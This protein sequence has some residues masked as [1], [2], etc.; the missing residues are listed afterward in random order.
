M[1]EFIHIAGTNGK[2]STAYYLADIIT[3]FDSCGLF[4]S[5][6]LF[7]P[8]ERFLVNGKQITQQDYDAYMREERTDM[9]EHLF[10]VW[11]RI[12]LRWFSDMH[13]DYAVIEAG[14]GGKNDCTNEID[15][16]IQILTPINY[17]HTEL[18]GNTLTKIAT[19]KSGIIKENATVIT[20]P[21]PE[22]AMRVIRRTCERKN[23]LLIELD[24]KAIRRKAAEEDG[25]TFSF[26]YKD[27][28]LTDAKIR[29]MSPTQVDNA[30][31]AVM[32]AAELGFT[33]EGQ[34]KEALAQTVFHA[35]AEL[36]D[37][38]I[39][40]GAHNVAAL[41]ELK[42]TLEKYYPREKITVLTAVMQDK[43]VLGITEVISE[44]ADFVV[45]TKADKAR[46]LP[47][48]Q[49]AGFFA[50][51][52]AIDDPEYAFLYAQNVA[53][54]KKTRLVVCGSFYLIDRVQNAQQGDSI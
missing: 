51:A 25:Q 27:I 9:E 17:D 41:S 42:K 50:K 13:V 32:A 3:K 33:D 40:D 49:L 4:T 20:H 38:V 29:A 43:D 54:H 16:K 47:A 44:F 31:V 15:S 19:E 48:R 36:H 8:L 37:D 46:G 23:A 5:P 30:C 22:E 10:C 34:I 52:K 45:C 53:K 2:G 14:I 28:R 26:T 24:Q 21:Q 18:L 12:A 11:M 39:Y 35:R 1:T 7:S 6:H